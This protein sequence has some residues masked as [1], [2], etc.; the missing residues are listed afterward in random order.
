M[1]RITMVDAVK[2]YAGV[3]FDQIHTL[4]EARAVAKEKG[5]EFEGRHKKGDILNPFFE[6]FAEEHLVQPTFVLDHPVEI[7]PLTK[8]KPGNPDYVERFE[9]FMNGW[10]MP[11][12]TLRSMI[13]LTRGAVLGTGRASG[14]GR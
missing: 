10:E 9:F 1:P 12:P 8:K 13:P 4:G 11:T 7:S 3:D 2:K 5:V 6:E 14:P